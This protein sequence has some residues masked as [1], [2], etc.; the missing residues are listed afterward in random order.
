MKENIKKKKSELETTYH[1]E[2]IREKEDELK[3]L[4]RIKKELINEKKT[5]QN[6]CKEQRKALKA[7]SDNQHEQDRR[8]KFEK[9][10]NDLKDEYKVLQ[11]EKLKL[12]TELNIL[13]S[14]L[15]KNRIYIRNMKK[16]IDIIKSKKPGSDKIIVTTEDLKEQEI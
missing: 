3:N 9:K 5:V 7:F 13:H 12:T 10:L 6:V 1:F 8:K 15:I 4:K 2:I 14:D 11:E 16:N